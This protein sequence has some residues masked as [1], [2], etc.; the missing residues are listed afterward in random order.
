MQWGR[1]P[2]EPNGVRAASHPSDQRHDVCAA[3]RGVRERGGRSPLTFAPVQRGAPDTVNGISA[4]TVK[5]LSYSLSE[6]FAS[7]HHCPRLSVHGTL[8]ET[9]GSRHRCPRL[10]IHGITVWIFQF[11]AA[12]WC[13]GPRQQSIRASARAGGPR[14]GGR[15]HLLGRKGFGDIRLALI[16]TWRHSD[17]FAPIC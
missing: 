13:Q 12:R 9:F 14:A 17:T 1:C 15:G 8:S 6:T 16:K 4:G 7:R 5:I 11:T 10:S 2:A 3:R